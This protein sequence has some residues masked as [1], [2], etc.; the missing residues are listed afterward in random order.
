M[1]VQL[2]L[3]QVS[4]LTLAELRELLWRRRSLLSLIL[5]AL[6]ILLSAWLL[7]KAHGTLGA[8]RGSVN[9]DSPEHGD[10]AAALDRMGARGLFLILLRLGDLPAALWI[11]QIFSLFWF[12]TLVGLVSCDCIALDVYRG[13][14][15]FV[16]L[17]SSRAAYY[18]AKL[19]SHF[20]LYA[21]L[22][23]VSLG[24][25][26][27]YISLAVPDVHFA[28]ALQLA[29]QYFLVFLPFLWCVVAATQLVSSW[30]SR[31]INALIRIHVLWIAFI[32][33]LALFPWASPL[34]SKWVLGLF[35]PFD[36]Y[37]IMSV[38]G[39]CAWGAFFSL[40]GMLFFLRRDV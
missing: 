34:W 31:P 11:F 9:L 1:H 5:Y 26:L 6:I 33:M 23:F 40:L 24:M 37:P 12:P 14:L 32:F 35:V 21:V 4:V 15:R 28:S 22:Q 39:Y 25:V 18:L 19:C 13:T 20:V 16:L 17:R 29:I 3:H 30:S 27:L 8:G 38:F 2:L 7:F 36:N 10:L